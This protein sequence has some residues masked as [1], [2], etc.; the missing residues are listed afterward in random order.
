PRGGGRRRRSGI[1]GSARPAVRPSAAV[2]R[3]QGRLRM[4]R[5]TVRRRGPIP[6]AGGLPRAPVR[7]PA[8]RAR[9]AGVPRRV[10]DARGGGVEPEN[11]AGTGSA[12]P[13]R[14]DGERAGAGGDPRGYTP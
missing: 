1:V 14:P 2:P 3:V 6:A 5:R 7:L 11:T 9:V 12:A 10:C 4:A 8:T 13:A